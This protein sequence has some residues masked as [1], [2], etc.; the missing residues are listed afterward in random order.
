M[1][2]CTGCRLPSDPNRLSTVTSSCPSI[3]GRKRM[4]EFMARYSTCRPS[5]LG[6][7]NTTVQAPQSPSA[8]PS[9]VPVRWITS[10]RYSSTVMVRCG[11][12]T[13]TIRPSRR[14][15]ISSTLS[16]PVDRIAPRR[17]QQRYMVMLVGMRD[18]DADH[19][20]FDE[21][22]VGEDHAAC[23]EIAG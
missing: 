7:P 22:R 15:R 23:P 20:L 19:G 17:D 16:S 14:K 8:Q 9:F 6:S 13:H 4:Q 5:A 18:A 10:R 2:C 1:A 12:R 3:V 11:F 21:R